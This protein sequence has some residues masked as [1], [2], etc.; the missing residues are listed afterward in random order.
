MQID[1]QLGSISRR[2]RFVQ[3][4]RIPIRHAGSKRRIIR[5]RREH[6]CRVRFDHAVD[7]S[8]DP[9]TGVRPARVRRRRA[10][11]A[12]PHA[13]AST[14]QGRLHPDVLPVELLN[15][16]RG[17]L[18]P[19]QPPRGLEDDA[20]L[21]HAG[22]TQVGAAPQEAVGRALEGGRALCPRPW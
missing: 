8:F 20:N 16:P 5:V 17:A 7:K 11:A 19:A 18:G 2:H 6:R 13:L 4:F 3:S 21:G 12:L 22:R 15:E 14:G 1:L 10:G 9:A